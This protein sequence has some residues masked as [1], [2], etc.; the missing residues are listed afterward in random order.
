MVPARKGSVALAQRHEIDLL[1][2]FPG[3]DV[4]PARPDEIQGMIGLAKQSIPDIGVNE[5]TAL[6]VSRH[7][8][9]SFWAIRQRERIIGGVAYL[10]LNEAGLD[11]LLLD[12]INFADPDLKL[13]TKPSEEAA[14][15]YIWAAL[16]KGRAALGLGAPCTR[17]REWPYAR[18]DYY[19]QPNTDEGM[20]FDMQL[21]F[22]RTPSFQRDLWIYRRRINRVGAA[23]PVATQAYLRSAA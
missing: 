15:I 1:Q 8:P 14:A 12:E 21:G 23:T 10:F 16:A 11:S 2:P 9:D 6:R 5:E 19:T 4:S 17:L 13:L 7:N 22:S 3:L 18:A 20:R